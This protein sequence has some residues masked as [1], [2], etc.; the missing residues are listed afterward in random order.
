MKNSIRFKP[1]TLLL[2]ILVA[3]PAAHL[4]VPLAPVLELPWSLAGLGLVAAGVALNI[5]ADLLFKGYGCVSAWRGPDVLV[6]GG[7]Y[8]LSRNPMYLGFALI[9][10]GVAVLLG[11]L[12]P[13]LLAA[14]FVPSADRLFIRGEEAVLTELYGDE[15]TAYATRVRRWI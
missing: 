1:P 11:S 3:M 5:I 2:V 7:P 8:V 15:W 9:L 4:I 13:L 6:T 10:V 14:S 12:A